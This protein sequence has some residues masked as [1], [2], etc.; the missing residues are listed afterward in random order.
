[1]FYTDDRLVYPRSEYGQPSLTIVV[2]DTNL[3]FF[4]TC[5]ACPEQYDVFINDKQ[6][7]YVR[8]RGGAL[9]AAYPD[10]EADYTYEVYFDNV[11]KG[12][13]EDDNERDFY[14]DKIAEHLYNKFIESEVV[15]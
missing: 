11:W 2:N 1:M 4:M 12:C 13:F 15:R 9:R 14:L 7:G 6:V 10:V 5:G 8:L 3:D